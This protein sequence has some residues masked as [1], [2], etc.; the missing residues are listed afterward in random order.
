MIRGRT[1]RVRDAAVFAKYI[2]TCCD[3]FPP[4]IQ[5]KLNIHQFIKL[6]A[7]SHWMHWPWVLI[8]PARKSWYIA[9]CHIKLIDV[10]PLAYEH[11]SNK[12]YFLCYP[13][14]FDDAFVHLLL[15]FPEEMKET[16]LN[17]TNG[18]VPWKDMVTQSTHNSLYIAMIIL[19]FASTSKSKF[20]TFPL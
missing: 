5:P 16:W 1:T 19:S 18:N 13:F 7:Q 9:L 6:N 2:T 3:N 10:S 15:S 8:W 11:E 4:C 17:S 14:Q 20:T 12:N